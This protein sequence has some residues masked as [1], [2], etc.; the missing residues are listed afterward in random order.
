MRISIFLAAAVLLLS[1]KA[2]QAG[3]TDILGAWHPERYVL[4]DGTE[5]HVSGLI[6]CNCL[7]LWVD[8]GDGGVVGSTKD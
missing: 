2:S 3:A 1:M 8:Q 7:P 6:F 4:E 5:L